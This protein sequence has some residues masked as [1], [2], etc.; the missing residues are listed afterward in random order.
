MRRQLAVVRL[1]S[2]LHTRH[3]LAVVRLLS[4]RHLATAHN[5]AD[6]AQDG[7]RRS[8]GQQAYNN[9]AA[10]PPDHARDHNQQQHRKAADAV[11]P[12]NDALP[13]ETGEK[14]R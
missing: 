1:L 11:D 4:L 7:E 5:R 12:C 10:Q 6:H 8:F 9:K 2:L 3:Q 14:R 13:Y